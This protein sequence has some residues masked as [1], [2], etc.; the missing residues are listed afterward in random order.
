MLQKCVLQIIEEPTKA[1]FDCGTISFRKQYLFWRFQP[2]QLYIWSIRL[3]NN[4]RAWFTSFFKAVTTKVILGAASLVINWFLFFNNLWIIIN[5]IYHLL[6]SAFS[7]TLS[8]LIRSWMNFWL[9][10]GY[11]NNIICKFFVELRHLIEEEVK[12]FTSCPVFYVKIFK[13]KWTL[14]LFHK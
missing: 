4:N 6:I 8:K 1:T 5:N 14:I 7:I 12:P 10:R 3:L 11:A 13:T 9:C 2:C